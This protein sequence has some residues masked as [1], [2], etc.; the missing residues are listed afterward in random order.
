MKPGKEVKR[1]SLVVS[2]ALIILS[3]LLQSCQKDEF[4]AKEELINTRNVR[5]CQ[6][7][8]ADNIICN[9][10]GDGG[11]DDDDAR[12]GLIGYLYEG[13]AEWNSINRYLDSGYQHPEAIYFSNFNVPVR[14]FSDGFL[15]GNDHL[16]DRSGEKLIEWFAIRVGGYVSLPDSKT[17]GHYHLATLSDDGIRIRVGQ[18][19]LID[20]PNTHAVTLDC[21][22]KTVDFE[23]GVEKE[24]DLQY[25][26]GPRHH[27]ALM[28]FVKKVS[29]AATYGAQ[30]C[31]S[32]NRP[33]DLIAAGYEVMPGAWFTLPAGY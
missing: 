9:P 3:L 21:A 23:A 13:E 14:A 1:V 8:R 27:I 4:Y 17:P 29:A 30:S 22:R 24:F 28:V 19:T 16:K 11:S 25:F 20:N 2:V 31:A 32:G 5:L 33:E 12:A 26:Q 6:D 10:F 7:G 15:L 18:E